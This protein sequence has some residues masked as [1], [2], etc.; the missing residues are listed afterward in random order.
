[1]LATVQ[2]ESNAL[3]FGIDFL[4]TGYRG[5]EGVA[6]FKEVIA[7]NRYVCVCK[8]SPI[9]VLWDNRDGTAD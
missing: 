7:C 6:V 4:E 3:A 2:R 8:A 9:A 5:I 1:M